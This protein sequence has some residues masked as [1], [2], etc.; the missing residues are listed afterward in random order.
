[1]SS[2]TVA[3]PAAPAAPKVPTAPSADPDGEDRLV[4][5]ISKD[6]VKFEVPMAIANMSTLAIT[7]V[8]SC[9]DGG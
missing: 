8:D 7:Q 3:A 4:T 6:D 1:M 2:A 9:D 5:L